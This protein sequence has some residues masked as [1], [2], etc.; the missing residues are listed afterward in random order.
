MIPREM[1]AMMERRRLVAE[2][3]TATA[4]QALGVVDALAAA[5]IAAMEISLTIPGAQEILTHLATRRD[6]L[7]GAGAVLDTHQANQA[8]SCGARFIASP[9]LVPEL[10]PACTDAHIACILG[11]LTPSEIIAAQRAGAEMVKVFPAEAL[12]GPMYIRALL[13]QLTHLSIQISGGFTAQNMGEYLALP[14]RTLALGSLL[15]PSV[16]VERGNWQAITSRAKAFVEFAANPHANA[17]RFLALLGVAPRPQPRA[18]PPTINLP[19]GALPGGQVPAPA[20]GSAAAATGEFHPWD[21][22]PVDMGDD[23]DWLR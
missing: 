15:V 20:A 23:E 7:I 3:R 21:S 19:P 6:V 14:V 12:G 11:A 16:L 10:V 5:G 17:A 13:R 9:I 4:V 18:E 22:R 2:V 1:I 8:I